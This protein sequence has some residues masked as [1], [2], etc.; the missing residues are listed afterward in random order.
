MLL[1]ESIKGKKVLVT[2]ASTGIGEQ[3]AYHYARLGASV[4]VTAR[5][6]HVLQQVVM[7]SYHPPLNHPP[8]K[9]KIVK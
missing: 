3:L 9:R 5:R 2:G 8:Q 6:Q 4:Y 7:K 1:S